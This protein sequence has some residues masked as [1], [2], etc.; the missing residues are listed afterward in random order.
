MSRRAAF[1]ALLLAL[2][3]LITLISLR[4]GVHLSFVLLLGLLLIADGAIR[5]ALISQERTK[6]SDPT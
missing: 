3:L 2:G 4:D 6:P 1:A 5:F